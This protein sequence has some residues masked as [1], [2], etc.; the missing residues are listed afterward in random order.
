MDPRGLQRAQARAQALETL[1]PT[2]P[3]QLIFGR[4]QINAFEAR[5][6]LARE[7]KAK[8]VLAWIMLRYFIDYPWRTRRG[9]TAASPAG[10]R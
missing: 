5:T 4:M 6:M 7:R 10:R 3:G 9:A 1:R 8:L 2:N